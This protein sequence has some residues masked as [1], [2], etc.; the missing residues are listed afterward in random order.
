M[1]LYLSH[2]FFSYDRHD[3]YN[4]TET[5]LKGDDATSFPESA[6][7]SSGNEAKHGR[8]SGFASFSIVFPLQGDF[9]YYMSSYLLPSFCSKR[10]FQSSILSRTRAFKG[11]MYTA[12]NAKNKYG[13]PF[14]FVDI[15]KSNN[16]KET[17]WS[18]LT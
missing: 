4:D 5:R 15:E 10:T 16:Y 8:R 18:G 2:E 3:R 12:C 9:K 1:K 14:S 17:N 11:A 13:V 6:L 7:S